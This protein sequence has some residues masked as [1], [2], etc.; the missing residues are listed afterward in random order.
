M[1]K[2]PQASGLYRGSKP[3]GDH[4]DILYQA[5]IDKSLNHKPLASLN[6][7]DK[8]RALVQKRGEFNEELEAI[9][10]ESD[11][12]AA[13]WIREKNTR[14]ELQDR[15]QK[16]IALEMLTGLLKHKKDYIRL[17]AQLLIAFANQEDIPRKYKIAVD[18]TDRG[19]VM[20]IKKT[21]YV[22]AFAPSGIPIYDYHACKMMAVR[23]GNTIA[24]LEGYHRST[25][26]GLLLPYKDEVKHYG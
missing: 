19:V 16:R 26:G 12:K 25:D 13:K 20:K 22:G 4:H 14:Q 2:D 9:G 15:Q 23:L 5:M 17:L 8:E 24:K 11:V 18:L 1:D 21:K 10:Q 7:L 3:L 6:Q